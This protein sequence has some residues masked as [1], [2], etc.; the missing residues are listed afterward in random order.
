MGK[1]IARTL[2]L[3]VIV[4]VAAGGVWLVTR[5]DCPSK[6]LAAGR[7]LVRGLR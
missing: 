5:T 6:A 3:A 2:R 1:F 4:G 7:K